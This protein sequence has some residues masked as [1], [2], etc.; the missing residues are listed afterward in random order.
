[1]CKVLFN[2]K[3]LRAALTRVGKVICRGSFNPA[4]AT[5]RLQFDGSSLIATGTNADVFISE[6]I[7]GDVVGASIEGCV[8]TE[9]DLL[10]KLIGK[11]QKHDIGLALN[12]VGDDLMLSVTTPTASYNLETLDDARWPEVPEVVLAIA[13][14]PAEVL[15]QALQRT[16]FCAI[17]ES[18]TGAVHYTNSVLFH[19]EKKT[20]TL[21]ATDGHRLALQEIT[22][23]VPKTRKRRD[24]QMLIPRQVTELLM[25]RIGNEPVHISRNDSWLRFAVGDCVIT[26]KLLNV[27]FPPYRKIIPT[28]IAATATMKV[29]D[30]LDLLPRSVTIRESS[31]KEPATYLRSENAA[32]VFT[33]RAKGNEGVERC[34]AITTGDLQIG[35]NPQYLLDAARNVKCEEMI[36][37]SE[38]KQ[39]KLRVHSAIKPLLVTLG[40]DKGFAYI[41]MPIRMD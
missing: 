40:A 23:G 12:Y 22:D 17:K 1:M 15:H 16:V 25:K 9:A 26:G 3:V 6:A 33:T 37:H 19:L 11:L 4:L 31:S 8:F 28:E 29:A 5:V 39:G 13:T 38:G 34:E 27:K 32:M 24:E 20:L 36:L 2:A 35:I 41:V 10:T 30:L 7:T 21:V 14:V 18:T